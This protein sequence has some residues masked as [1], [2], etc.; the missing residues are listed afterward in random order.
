MDTTKHTVTIPIEDYQELIKIKEVH[1]DMIKSHLDLIEQELNAKFLYAD[2]SRKP[3]RINRHEI[4]KGKEFGG[5][6]LN[7]IKFIYPDE[8]IR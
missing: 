3:I 8:T 6:I 2:F 1:F 7:T 5:G 4:T